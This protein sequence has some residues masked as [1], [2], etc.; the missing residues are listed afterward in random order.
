MSDIYHLAKADG[1]R[2][3]KADRQHLLA[4]LANGELPD[5]TLIQR[6]G[7]VAWKP[8][9]S[10]YE[11][12]VSSMSWTLLSALREVYWTRCFDFHSRAGR[13][14]LWY[15]LVGIIALNHCLYWAG[16]QLYGW[17]HPLGTT[18]EMLF[19]VVVLGPIVVAELLSLIPTIGVFARRLHDLGLSGNNLFLLLI[20]F[21]LIHFLFFAACLFLPSAAPNRW[22]MRPKSPRQT[23]L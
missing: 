10:L 8:V 20:P 22:G 21:P 16:M 23:P 19:A 18:V 2:F 7:E 4:K 15:A 9:S 13:E 11:Q 14:E 6:E 1:T 12:P 17:L 5:D 3:G